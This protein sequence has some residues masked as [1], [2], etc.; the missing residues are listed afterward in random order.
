MKLTVYLTLIPIGPLKEIAAGP[1]GAADA[2]ALAEAHKKQ[3]LYL[4]DEF[5]A[6]ISLAEARAMYGNEHADDLWKRGDDAQTP[7]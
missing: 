6:Q 4:K 7:H 2:I 1:F 3:V 5:G